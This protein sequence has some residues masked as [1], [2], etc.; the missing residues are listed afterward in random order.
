MLPVISGSVTVQR[1]SLCAVIKELKADRD[2]PNPMRK[3]NQQQ[4]QISG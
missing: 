4:Q 3:N 2:A 1:T